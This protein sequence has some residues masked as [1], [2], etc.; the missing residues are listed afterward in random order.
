MFSLVVPFHSDVDRLRATLE[1]FRAREPRYGIGELL[2]CHNGAPPPDGQLEILRSELREHERLLHTPDRGIGAGYKLG[3]REAREPWVILSASD[4]PFGFSDVEAFMTIAATLSPSE[5]DNLVALG[6]KLHKDST[7][8][9]YGLLRRSMSWVFYLARLL[10]LGRHTP[11]DS[12]GTV[13]V[14]TALAARISSLVQT[15]DFFFTPMFVARA[16]Q[17][18]CAICEVPV[19]YFAR[20]DAS[21][22]GVVKDSLTMLMRVLLLGLERKSSK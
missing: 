16:H 11:R 21:S 20:G 8:K 9:G 15:D 13:L 7:V 14:N 17:N 19:T 10:C 5:A 18:G 6:S 3:I 12:Q 1:T 2:L 4:L 22:V